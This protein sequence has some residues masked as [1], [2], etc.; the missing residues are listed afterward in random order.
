MSSVERR[1]YS[2][3]ELSRFGDITRQATPH[4]VAQVSHGPWVGFNGIQAL[5]LT[6]KTVYR[7][8][9]GWA[10]RPERVI[11]KYPVS[12]ISDVRWT[13]SR[14]GRSGRLTFRVAG[15]RRSFASKWQE[16]TDLAAELERLAESR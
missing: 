13:S 3:A 12:D 2:A 8:Q 6:G 16:A 11:S 4:L 5:V 7:I 9:Q 15:S 1:R 10:L 14:G